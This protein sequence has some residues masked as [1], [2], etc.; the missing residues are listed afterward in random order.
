MKYVVFILGFILAGASQGTAQDN[1]LTEMEI[2]DGWILLFDGSSV[3]AWRGYN[4]K[5]FPEAGWEIRDGY[6]VVHKSDGSEQGQGGT[7]I[8]RERF[9][10]FEFSVD[11]MLSDTANS[12]IFYLVR[13]FE[14]T[15]IWHNAPEFQLIDDD[16][17]YV[18]YGDWMN[19]HRTGDNYD[20]EAA[21]ENYSNPIGDWNTARVIKKGNKVEHWINGNLAVS[22]EIGSIKWMNQVKKS[23]F[24]EF[25]MYGK[26]DPGSIGLQDH[27]HEVRFKN[28]KVR[29]L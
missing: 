7:I 27:G 20:L 6:I 15:P 25:P 14:D 4:K 26:A 5:E 2:A 18:E 13:E 1:A 8:T 3:N 19:T 9:K 11:F 16:T 10:S 23:K 12:G 24:S 21:P 29:R 17:Y 22:Y 28:I